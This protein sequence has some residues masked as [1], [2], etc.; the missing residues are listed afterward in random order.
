MLSG[1]RLGRSWRLA[2]TVRFTLSEPARV[3]LAVGQPVAGRRSGGRCRP[4]RAT[5]RGPRCTITKARGAIVVAGKAGGN[6]VRLSRA[7][8][9]TRTL[10]PGPYLERRAVYASGNRGTARTARF[11]I[12]RYGAFGC[13]PA[14]THARGALVASRDG[15]CPGWGRT[16]WRLAP[17]AV[18]A[19]FCAGLV[20][21][22]LV[23]PPVGAALIVGAS[24]AGVAACALA[25]RARA[26]LVLLGVAAL[27][28]GMGWGGARIAA[29][30]APDLD[31]PTPVAGTVRAEH[32]LGDGGRR[33][34]SAAAW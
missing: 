30:A 9:K 11:T 10:K 14:P 3:T 26:A 1:L 32:V 28:M 34:L 24:A 15:R 2:T 31:L 17:H 4:A 8:T 22:L 7:L 16:R 12:A 18:L 23:G 5:L 21:A 27:A 13:R 25:G 6:R 19:L 33:G 29:T 20:C